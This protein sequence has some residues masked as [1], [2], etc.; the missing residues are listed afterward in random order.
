MKK[1]Q[2][3]KTKRYEL[4]DE[5]LVFYKKFIEPH[6]KNILK[7][8]SRNLFNSL[9]KEEWTSWLG[10]VDYGPHFQ[11]NPGVQIDLVYRRSDNILVLC[12]MKYSKKKIKRYYFRY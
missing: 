9:V 7:N 4:T 1:K 5:F 11:K 6:M 12:E 10:I 2:N 3:S 8:E